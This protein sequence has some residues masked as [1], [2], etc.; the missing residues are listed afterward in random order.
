MINF[1]KYK[2]IFLGL[3]AILV[4]SS[5]VAMSTWGLNLG[6]EFT[7]GSVLKVE[8][9][10]ERPS[11]E[12]I[13]SILSEFDLG[14]VTLRDVDEK[15]LEISFQEV[16][17]ETE[18]ATIKEKLNAQS[19]IDPSKTYVEEIQPVVGSIIKKKTFRSIIL[20]LLVTLIFITIAFRGVSRYINSWYYAVAATVALCHDVIIPLGLVAWLGQAYGVQFNLP[21]V[22]ALLTIFGYSIND[23]IVVYDRIRENFLRKPTTDIDATVNKSINETVWRSVAATS[24]TLLPLLMVHFIGGDE[25]RYFS[26]ILIVGIF[27]GA[28]SSIFIASPLLLLISGKSIKKVEK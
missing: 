12:D 23:T 9:V 3:S 26:L 15:G 6:I 22:A 20:S 17:S 25:L 1:L 8:Y 21:I 2:N 7:Q 11:H 24:T 18:K 14:T 4:V 27:L 5:I 10:T 16:K 19:E 13:E 28:Y